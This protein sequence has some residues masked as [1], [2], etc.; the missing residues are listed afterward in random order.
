MSLCLSLPWLW[1]ALIPSGAPRS[2]EQFP[3]RTPLSLGQREQKAID[4]FWST[5][6]EATPF[7]SVRCL[8]GQSGSQDHFQGRGCCGSREWSWLG[9]LGVGPWSQL[10]AP[11]EKLFKD[12]ETPAF[13]PPLY[14]RL[15]LPREGPA[16][17]GNFCRGPVAITMKR[18]TGACGMANVNLG[19][20]S[21]KVRNGDKSF[22]APKEFSKYVLYAPLSL[23]CNTI[24]SSS[25]ATCHLW[26]SDADR[27]GN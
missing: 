19:A 25:Y 26:L 10:W 3:S 24:V 20:F 14:F 6:S 21:H 9:T 27:N 2:M 17:P 8:V 13:W 7:T 12:T 1:S 23:C 11:K 16:V 22:L 5:H 15:S 4:G 18:K